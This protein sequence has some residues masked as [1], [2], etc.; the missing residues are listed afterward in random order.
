MINIDKKTKTSKPVNNG[1]K[2]NARNTCAFMCFDVF[3]CVFQI[4]CVWAFPCGWQELGAERKLE[5]GTWGL[6]AVGIGLVANFRLEI[7]GSGLQTPASDS[8]L[9]RRL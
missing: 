1:K 7:V 8:R 3:S 5:C 9:R 4:L 6:G 2:S